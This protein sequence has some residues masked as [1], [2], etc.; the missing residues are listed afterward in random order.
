MVAA[1]PDLQ[2]ICQM[3]DGAPA[4]LAAPESAPARRQLSVALPALG[5]G[6]G[7]RRRAGVRNPGRRVYSASHDHGA[8]ARL[9]GVCG[10]APDEHEKGE[11]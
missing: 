4:S 2:E 10:A 3:A 5:H 1:Q 7:T 11:T 9:P 8:D 6:H